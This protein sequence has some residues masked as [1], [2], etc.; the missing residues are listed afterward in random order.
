MDDRKL[1]PNNDLRRI[2]TALNTSSE[3]FHNIR[4][5]GEVWMQSGLHPG[6]GMLCRMT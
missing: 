5:E 6:G 2:N 1:L 4:R 3:Y